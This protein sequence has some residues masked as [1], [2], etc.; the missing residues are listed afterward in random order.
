MMI[1]RG[2]DH[3]NSPNSNINTIFDKHAFYNYNR[4][5]TLLD[6]GPHFV[7]SL[8]KILERGYNMFKQNAYIYQY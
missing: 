1:F 5:V 8:D 2:Q 4:S 3:P 6:N 7:A